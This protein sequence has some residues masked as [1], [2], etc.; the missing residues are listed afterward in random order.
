MAFARLLAACSS[1]YH[2]PDGICLKFVNSLFDF[3]CG[4]FGLQACLPQLLA[5]YVLFE[6]RYF[7]F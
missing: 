6:I 1:P 4:D 2:L 3:G 7:T 5:L